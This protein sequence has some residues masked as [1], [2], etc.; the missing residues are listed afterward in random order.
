MVIQTLSELTEAGQQFQGFAL[1]KK[2]ELGNSARNE[3]FFSVVLGQKEKEVDAKLWASDFGFNVTPNDIKEIIKEGVVI[4]VAGVSNVYKEVIQLKITSFRSIN[5]ED[6]VNVNDFVKSAVIPTAEIKAQI[7]DYLSSITDPLIKEITETLLSKYEKPFFEF[8]AAMTH[9]HNYASGLSY[10]SLGM[11]KIAD[12]LCS[13]YPQLNRD[14]MIS[15]CVLHDLGKVFELSGPIATTY[16]VRGNLLGHINMIIMEIEKEAE[17]LRREKAEIYFNETNRTYSEETITHLLH[18]IV[19]HHGKLEWGSNI[20]PK[21]LEAQL[22]HL[23]D[24]I[25]SRAN[26]MIDGLAKASEGQM[27]KVGREYLY[28]P[29]Q[30]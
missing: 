6:N 16:T 18:I 10:H 25:D 27:T 1:V 12:N 19:S 15:S 4:S 9:H 8:P 17:T 24:M 28:K 30:S 23:V 3:P 7:E 2:S 5:E 13:L 21:S 26:G 20:L 14:L 22:F 29:F 11:I